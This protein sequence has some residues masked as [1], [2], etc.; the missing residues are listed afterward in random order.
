MF[1]AD[2]ALAILKCR[3]RKR[4]LSFGQ[5]RLSFGQRV[6][7]FEA[8]FWPKRPIFWSLRA[9]FRMFRIH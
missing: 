8:I 7:I 5:T 3:R 6:P 4:I 9:I 1:H 2:A